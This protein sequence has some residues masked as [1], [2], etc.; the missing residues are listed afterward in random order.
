VTVA[1]IDTYRRAGRRHQLVKREA[2]SLAPVNGNG[3]G[4]IVDRCEQ[5]ALVLLDASVVTTDPAGP[6]VDRVWSK[7]WVL[8]S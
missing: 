2:I 4:S 5:L 8:V 6:L 7:L 1:K 3:P